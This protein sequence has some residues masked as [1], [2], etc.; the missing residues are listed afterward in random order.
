MSL[1]ERITY[2]ARR[3]PSFASHEAWVPRWREHW[4]LAAGQPESATVARYAQGEVIDDDADPPYDGM[5][6]SEYRS[7][8]DRIR[9][10]SAEGYHA[11]MSADEELVFDRLI[12][13]CSFFGTRHLI[14]GGDRSPYAVVRFVRRARPGDDFFANW[15]RWAAWCTG[16]PHGM[17]GAAQTRALPAPVG[18]WGLD[19]DGCEDYRFA[20]LGA[21]R[22]FRDGEELARRTAAGPFVVAHTV[23]IHETVLKDS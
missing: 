11:I 3:N 15:E 2:L 16:L 13:E 10:R 22:R 7:P 20:T 9:N 6:F 5:A 14:A 1:P 8:A 17:L 4:A 19:V 21:A 18:G 23:V 12:L